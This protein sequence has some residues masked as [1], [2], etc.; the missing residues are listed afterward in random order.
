MNTW[1][2]CE[3]CGKKLIQRK[4]NGIFLFRFGKSSSQESFVELEI[5][6]SIRMKCFRRSCGYTNVV[7]F[8]PDQ[9]KILN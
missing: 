1:V 8:F 3:K 4:E 5:F 2:N 9:I 6:G 7:N